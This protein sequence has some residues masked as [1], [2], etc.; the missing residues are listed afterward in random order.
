VPFCFELAFALIAKNQLGSPGSG[1]NA[2]P[3]VS[4]GALFIRSNKF[5]YCV[6]N[7]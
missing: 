2:T 6:A 7:R 3:A 5:L 4:D 1:F